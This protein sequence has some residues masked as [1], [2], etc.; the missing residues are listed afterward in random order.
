MSAAECP[1]RASGVVTDASPDSCHVRWSLE[2]LFNIA[3]EARI[4]HFEHLEYNVES[5]RPNTSAGSIASFGRR[6]LIRRIDANHAAQS[7]QRTSLRWRGDP[8]GC[9]MVTTIPVSVGALAVHASC[10]WRWVQAYAPGLYKR[11]RPHLWPANKSYRI[12]ET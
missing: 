2:Y 5:V 1:L 10:V 12:D 3:Q 7:V 8:F 4:C 9:A 11:C 6:W